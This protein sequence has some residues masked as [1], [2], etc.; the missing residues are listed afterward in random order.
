MKILLHTEEDLEFQSFDQPGLEVEPRDPDA[1]YSALQMFATS[2][3]LCT[4]SV[5]ASYAD[6]IDVSDA[7]MTMRIKWSYADDPFRIG[8]MD[9]D[10]RWPGVPDSRIKAARAAANHCTLHH[11]LEQPPEFVTRVHG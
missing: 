2:V 11:T 5:L 1:H 8:H 7:D 9:M 4:Y 6:T 3:A 10:I